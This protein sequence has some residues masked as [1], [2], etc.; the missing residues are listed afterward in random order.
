MPKLRPL[1]WTAALALLLAAASAR[2]QTTPPP[3]YTEKLSIARPP[4]DNRYAG[5]LA[6]GSTLNGGNT[7]SYAVTLG[8]RFQLNRKINQLTAEITGSWAAAYNSEFREVLKTAS[9]TM[10]KLR[11]D[12]FVAKNDALFVALAPRRDP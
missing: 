4:V 7:Q 8:G 11:Y 10:G 5:N 3:Q 12:V 6:L 9:N 2:A 1:R